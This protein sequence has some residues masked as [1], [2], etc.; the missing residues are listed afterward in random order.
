MHGQIICC[1][2]CGCDNVHFSGVMV[3]QGTGRLWLDKNRTIR[4]S[5]AP[6]SGRGSEVAVGYWCEWG[7]EFIVRQQFYKGS[8]FTLTVPGPIGLGGLWRD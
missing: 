4:E 1:P 8:I 7:C 6:N 3:H 2:L 5:A